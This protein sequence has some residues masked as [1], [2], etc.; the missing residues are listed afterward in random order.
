MAIW[1][2]RSTLSFS[3]W[4]FIRCARFYSAN[5]KACSSSALLWASN[6]SAWRR[7]NSAYCSCIT[8][9]FSICSCWNCC[10]SI[11]S[12]CCCLFFRCCSFSKSSYW[13]YLS[14]SSSY[15]FFKAWASFHL[16]IRSRSCA[17]RSSSAS[18]AFSILM[19]SAYS[20]AARMRTWRSASRTL[21]SSSWRY[22]SISCLRSISLYL[23]YS[24]NLIMFSSTI[25]RW[26]SS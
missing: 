16:R 18:L 25:K 20:C 6:F 1:A 13:I 7:S 22:N 5:L 3:Y 12:S 8:L 26:R 23:R 21:A 10:L 15:C 24:A 11:S 19:R 14:A 9:I 4:S 17:T 2:S